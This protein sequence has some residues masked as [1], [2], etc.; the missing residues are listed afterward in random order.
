[1][2]VQGSSLRPSAARPCAVGVLPRT[3]ASGSSSAG[4]AH[5][6]GPTLGAIVVKGAAA[7]LAGTT[8]VAAVPACVNALKSVDLPGRHRAGAGTCLNAW[9]RSLKRRLQP[10]A[11]GCRLDARGCSLEH[12]ELQPGCQGLQ[13]FSKRR[14]ACGRLADQP[15]PVVPRAP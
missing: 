3:S 5:Q 8:P 11:Q 12:T 1:M 15:H 2:T 14:L 7:V 9:G 10:H 13:A 4:A 6:A